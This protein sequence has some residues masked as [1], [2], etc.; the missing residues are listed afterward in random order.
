[1][2]MKS[3]IHNFFDNHL[4]RLSNKEGFSKYICT[5]EFRI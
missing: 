5:N 2:N 1:M 4:V 3:I